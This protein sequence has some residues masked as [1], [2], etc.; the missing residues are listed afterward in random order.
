ML[1]SVLIVLGCWRRDGA[2]VAAL[3]PPTASSSASA[4]CP[5]SIGYGVSAHL[6]N[7]ELFPGCAPPPFNEY[8][9]ICGG[10]CPMPCRERTTGERYAAEATFTYAG[11]GL[12]TLDRRALSDSDREATN[13]HEQCEYHDGKLVSCLDS[14]NHEV[15][16]IRDPDGRIVK[17]TYEDQRAA[18]VTYDAQGRIATM[19]F[20]I[21]GSTFRRQVELTWDA[22]RL[23]VERT[24]TSGGSGTS[25]GPDT[26]TVEY[27]YDLRGRPTHSTMGDRT[28]T[29]HTSTGLVDKTV[30]VTIDGIGTTTFAYDADRR[31]THIV[32]TIGM[33]KTIR[34]YDY[35]CKLTH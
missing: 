26:D 35:E 10:T 34:E 28:A 18:V 24:T 1:G 6:W 12:A 13:L 22:E 17:I 30:A 14:E 16:I 27:A 5:S 21:A 9:V 31:P 32:S 7:H 3:A 15:R 11:G 20:T 8:G 23:L 19:D 4:T 29:Y 33:D 25:Q 2:G